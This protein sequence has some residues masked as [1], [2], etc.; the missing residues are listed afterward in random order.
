MGL[1]SGASCGLLSDLPWGVRDC[2]WGSKVDL[3]NQQLQIHRCPRAR[4]MGSTPSELQKEA[5]QARGRQQPCW[6][7]ELAVGVGMS[8]GEHN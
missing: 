2:A 6:G 4:G 7:G 1:A 5:G 3:L 8:D